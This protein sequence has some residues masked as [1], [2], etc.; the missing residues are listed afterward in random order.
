[1]GA[2]PKDPAG[3]LIAPCRGFANVF[4]GEYSSL[5]PHPRDPAPAAESFKRALLSIT[6]RSIGC[7]ANVARLAGQ[8]VGAAVKMTPQDEPRSQS[9]SKGEEDH[10]LAPSARAEFPFRD[11]TGIGIVFQPDRALEFF[12]EEADD[13]NFIPTGKVRRGEDEAFSAVQGTAAAYPRLMNGRKFKSV[14][15]GD[16]VDGLEKLLEYPLPSASGSGGKGDT[17]ADPH[18]FIAQDNGAFGSADVQ[19]EEIFF[20][21]RSFGSHRAILP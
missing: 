20:A 17:A 8:I 2:G 10:V 6:Q 12:L 1:M 3:S 18:F 4:R 15:E 19:A 16:I 7:Q 9:R 5:F 21:A 11:G 13:G 14:A